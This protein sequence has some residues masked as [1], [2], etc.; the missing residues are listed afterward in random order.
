M[1]DTSILWQ[2]KITAR[3]QKYWR[4]SAEKHKYENVPNDFEAIITID[5]SGLVVS[6]PELFER[7]L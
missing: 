2:G 4:L 1:Q 7:V 3:E 5:K 6:Y